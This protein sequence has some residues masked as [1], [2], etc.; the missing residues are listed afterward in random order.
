MSRKRCESCQGEYHDVGADGMLYFHVCPPITRVQVTRGGS[1][2]TVDLADLQPTD[3][4]TVQRGR[5][6]VAILVSALQADDVRVGDTTGA[7]PE[8][9]DENTAPVGGTLEGRRRI[10]AP[11]RGATT[12]PG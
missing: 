12:I 7:R 11:G 9:R 10:K 2:R 4:V 6:Q 3:T 1:V 8:A 5:N